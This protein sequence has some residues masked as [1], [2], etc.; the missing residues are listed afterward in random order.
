M[1]EVV[2][3]EQPKLIGMRNLLTI[4]ALL[5]LLAAA[6]GFLADLWAADHDAYRVTHRGSIP[7]VTNDA[8]AVSAMHEIM[9]PLKPSDES[10]VV[11]VEAADGCDSTYS[12]ACANVRTGP[13]TEFESAF[14]MR[15]GVV[16][17]VEKT[18]RRENRDWYKITFDEWVRYPDRLGE[19]LYVASDV[20][21]SFAREAP[22]E[23]TRKTPIPATK[24]IVVDL[25]EQTLY[26]MDGDRVYMQAHVST[27]LDG[28]PTEPGTFHIYRKMPSRYMQGPIPGF[29]EDEYDLPGVPWTMYFTY[30]GAAIHGA[31]WHSDF[32]E[33]H[34]HGCVNLTPE[35]ARKLY[36]WT[37][38]N[39][40]VIVQE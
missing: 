34:S 2:A 35:N 22:Q 37:P 10:L 21:R 33:Q 4:L 16:L 5:L 1:D 8:Q 19:E 20:V 38:L 32:G 12:G 23:A 15:D 31:Y 40:T 3:N 29:T 36:D 7:V 27:G 6:V 11:Y 28:T 13:G 24:R 25:S 18:V 26:A 9:M 14:K 30:S 39:T 17:R